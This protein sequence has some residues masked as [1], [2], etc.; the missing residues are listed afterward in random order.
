MNI[1]TCYAISHCRFNLYFPD[2]ECLG[3]LLTYLVA[4]YILSTETYV[5]ILNL[6]LIYDLFMCGLFSLVTKIWKKN[7]HQTHYLYS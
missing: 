7:F 3:K 2:G 5:L 6:C 1:L 4:F